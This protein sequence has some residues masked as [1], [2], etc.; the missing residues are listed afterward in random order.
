MK[1]KIVIPQMGESISEATIG[2]IFKAS[3]SLVK[4]DDEILELETDKVNQ[5]IFAPASGRVTLNVSSGDTVAIGQEVG[6]ID[7]VEEEEKEA[8]PPPEAEVKVETKGEVRLQ[9][10][11]F[12]KA[13]EAPVK[14]PVEKSALP[15]EE[16]RTK[17]SRLRQTIAERLVMAKTETAMLTTF[18]EVD[19]SEVIALREQYQEAFTKKYG[20]KMGFMP[21]F[22]L[23]AIDALKEYP[24]VNSHI[25]GDEIVEPS[26][27]NMGIAVS[28][29]RG[30]VVP[31]I[32]HVE[33]LNFHEIEER[34]ANLADKGRKGSLTV[35]EIRGGTFTITNGGLF[36]S[37]LSTPILNFPQSAILGMHTIQ[38]RAVVVE[39]EIKIR[40]MMYLALSYD[41]RII[42]GR[43][44]VL[45]LK[46]IKGL[47]ETPGRFVIGV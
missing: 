14:Q 6:L 8:P 12:I 44:A 39:D 29:D 24:L 13:L 20:F 28:T 22:V 36:G 9:K 37:L 34:I 11:D 26:Q 42:D 47:L 4:Q 40:P 7:I 17:M 19:L 25:D 30:L 2:E 41:H 10:E 18:N 32:P 1:E 23:A 46:H 21:F 27:I 31:V 15:Q 38:K 43:E 33:A 45:F 5:V 3:G 35:D 16:K